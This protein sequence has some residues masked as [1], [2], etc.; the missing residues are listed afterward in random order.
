MAGGLSLSVSQM[1]AIAELPKSA[2]KASSVFGFVQIAFASLLGYIVGLMY[3]NSLL[4]TAVGVI[5]A[6]LISAAGYLIIRK[7][8]INNEAS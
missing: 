5:V 4:P 7:A 3:N 8:H 1:G 2:G 6:V